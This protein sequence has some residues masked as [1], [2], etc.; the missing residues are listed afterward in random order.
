M[1]ALSLA[2]LE[3]LLRRERHSSV[4]ARK[5]GKSVHPGGALKLDT[6]SN[7]I[8]KARGMVAAKA[9]EV[10]NRQQY[11]AFGLMSASWH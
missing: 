6:W 4:P 3:A 2:I 11:Q 7:H 10:N 9:A 1:K 5:C 8:Q